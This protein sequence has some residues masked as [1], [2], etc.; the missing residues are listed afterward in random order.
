MPAE[1]RTPSQNSP[2]APIPQRPERRTGRTYADPTGGR[3]V[4]RVRKED[5]DGAIARARAARRALL[6]GRTP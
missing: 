6:E 5:K 1:P 2:F 3:A 4:G